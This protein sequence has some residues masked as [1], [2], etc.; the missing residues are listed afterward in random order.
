MKILDFLP[1][2]DLLEKL[3]GIEDGLKRRRQLG[4]LG[5]IGSAFAFLAWVGNVAGLMPE[6]VTKWLGSLPGSW[7]VIGAT[8]LAAFLALAF[9]LVVYRYWLKE[10]RRPIRYTCSIGEF[11]VVATGDAKTDS[12]V[13]ERMSRLRY[14]L[15][16]RLNQRVGRL[17]FSFSVD[18]KSTTDAADKADSGAGVST[19]QHIHIEGVY[20]TQNRKAAADEG[21]A[22][23]LVVMPRVR[24][25]GAESPEKLAK[26]VFYPIRSHPDLPVA[27]YEEM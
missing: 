23:E 10:T 14:D 26:P 21:D 5:I 13:D 18:N 20:Y 9:F 17:M 16:T 3:E 12:I 11:A 8:C 24:I 27:G 15:A 6:G 1:S 19:D 22:W 2:A 4:R 7:K 25:G